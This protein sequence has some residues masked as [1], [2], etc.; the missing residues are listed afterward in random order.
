MRYALSFTPSPSSLLWE[1]GSKWIG[2]DSY[3]GKFLEQPCI[4]GI[5]SDRLWELTSSARYFGL[6]AIIKFPFRLASA[7]TVEKLYDLLGSYAAQQQSVALTGLELQNSNDCF[8]LQSQTVPIQLLHI[9][10]GAVKMLNQVRAPL[11]PSEC[12][13]LKAE[14]L[15]TQEKRNVQIWGYPYVFDQYKFQIRVTSRITKMVEKEMMYSALNRFFAPVCAE[16]LLIDALSLYVENGAGSPLRF[17]HRFTF[18]KHSS[19]EKERHHY[20]HNTTQNFHSRYQ[21]SAP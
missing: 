16:P 15:T 11:N 7:T 21:R 17:L 10:S 20:A 9:A 6:Q 5:E 18:F 3:F 12:A 1:T 2:L 19:E 4:S 13:R 14:F 8:F